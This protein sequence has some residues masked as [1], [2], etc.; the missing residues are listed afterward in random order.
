M[1]INIVTVGKPKLDYAR[2]GFNEYTSR[3]SRLATLKIITLSDRYAYSTDKFKEVLVNTYVVALDSR[4]QQFDS[5]GLAN[6]LSRIENM[7]RTVSF[8][9]G[10]P[11][12]LP[13]GIKGSADMIWSF[14][15]LTLPHDLAMLVLAESLYRGLMIKSGLPYHR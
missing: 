12:G 13:D 14:G 10:G 5:I 15:K 1:K 8:V 9:I 11:D 6:Q 4:G 3:L 2:L 7:S